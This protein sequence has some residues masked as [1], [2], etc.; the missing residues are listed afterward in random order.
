MQR[1]IL[2]L[3]FEFERRSAFISE[4]EGRKEFYLAVG[5]LVLFCP[6]KKN[7]RKGFFSCIE[8]VFFTYPPPWPP[9]RGGYC[10]FYF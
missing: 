5:F 6:P 4:A 1:R 2:T 7:E 3:A 8:I 9:R 10:A